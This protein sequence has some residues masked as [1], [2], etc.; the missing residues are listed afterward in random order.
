LTLEKV[1]LYLSN[2]SEEVGSLQWLNK[3]DTP[4]V[5]IW[6]TGSIGKRRIPAPFSTG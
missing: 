3:A 5:K 4:G 6:H 2:D 1:L